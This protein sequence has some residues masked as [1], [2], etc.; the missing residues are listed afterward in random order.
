MTAFTVRKWMR[1]EHRTFQSNGDKQRGFGCLAREKKK[2]WE[3]P[4]PKSLQRRLFA[5]KCQRSHYPICTERAEQSKPLSP[6]L[7]VRVKTHSHYLH[8]DMKSLQEYKGEVHF[9]M[10]SRMK[11]L[12]QV[13]SHSSLLNLCWLMTRLR[14]LSNN[15]VGQR[16]LS[17]LYAHTPGVKLLDSFTHNKTKSNLTTK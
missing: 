1:T 6:S 12:H 16:R 13:H 2:E 11:P 7:L 4:E 14:Q 15:C 10:D 8:Y 17:H 5:E 3:K 9:N